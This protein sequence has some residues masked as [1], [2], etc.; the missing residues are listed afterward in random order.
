MS[1]RS[2]VW[3]GFTELPEV[4]VKLPVMKARSGRR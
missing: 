4:G 2:I 3:N 1:L